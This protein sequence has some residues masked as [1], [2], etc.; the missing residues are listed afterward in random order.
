MYKENDKVMVTCKEISNKDELAYIASKTPFGAYEVTL[1]MDHKPSSAFD[2][3]R[4]FGTEQMRF[5]T[6]QEVTD[7]VREWEEKHNYKLEGMI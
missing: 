5:A 1:L 4:V 2:P 7:N 3:V 6:K